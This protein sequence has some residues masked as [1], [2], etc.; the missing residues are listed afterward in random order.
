MTRYG[1][2][3]PVWRLSQATYSCTLPRS[4]IGRP[5]WLGRLGPLMTG[6]FEGEGLRNG[7]TSGNLSWQYV[8]VGL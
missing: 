7:P 3:L 4:L 5:G 6:E 1:D 2:Q 8:S